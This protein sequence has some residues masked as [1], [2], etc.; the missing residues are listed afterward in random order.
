MNRINIILPGLAL[1]LTCLSCALLSYFTPLVQPE[2]HYAKFTIVK[3]FSEEKNTMNEIDPQVMVWAIG[4][5]V[6]VVILWNIFKSGYGS[7]LIFGAMAFAVIGLVFWLLLFRGQDVS[8]ATSRDANL[9]TIRVVQPGDDSVVDEAYS[10]INRKNAGTN[11]IN[12]GGVA[13]YTM[14]IWVTIVLFFSIGI[15]LWFLKHR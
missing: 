7:I 3:E 13:V 5:I 14:L 12:A 2:T 10:E 8:T 1:A 11:V 9:Q 15:F 4:I 6:V